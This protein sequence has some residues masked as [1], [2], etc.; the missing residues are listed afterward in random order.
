[1]VC[2]LAMWLGSI[3]EHE[4][5]EP[6]YLK[7][8][9]VWTPRSV[10]G[11]HGWRPRSQSPSAMEIGTSYSDPNPKAVPSSDGSKGNRI[12]RQLDMGISTMSMIP[13]RAGGALQPSVMTLAA[14]LVIHPPNVRNRKEDGSNT[15]LG[16]SW[17]VQ[18][19]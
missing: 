14:G 19:E 2:W 17:F 1:V 10:T 7:E 11:M 3:A 13:G 9:L 5:L 12:E 6:H 8:G 16:P 15:K 18:Y 4:L